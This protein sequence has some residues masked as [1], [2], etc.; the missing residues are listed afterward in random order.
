[1]RPGNHFILPLQEGYRWM[2]DGVLPVI[3]RHEMSEDMAL[4]FFMGEVTKV[5]VCPE[6]FVEQFKEFLEAERKRE[7][8]EIVPPEGLS[9]D[10]VAGEDGA[11]PKRKE[12]RLRILP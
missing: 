8:M 3:A 7:I 6:Q 4:N 10:G 5:T 12:R 9:Q 11:K 2:N 1:L